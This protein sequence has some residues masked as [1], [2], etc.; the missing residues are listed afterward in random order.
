MLRIEVG[1]IEKIGGEKM[2]ITKKEAVKPASLKKLGMTVP[3][4]LC[5][6]KIFSNDNDIET[7]T[8]ID[9][10]NGS[11]ILNILDK[12]HPLIHTWLLLSSISICFLSALFF[13][14]P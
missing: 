9:C 7:I 8:T 5:A 3:N 1:Q 12:Q 4:S 10:F 2:L 6:S 14:F 11:A 13:I